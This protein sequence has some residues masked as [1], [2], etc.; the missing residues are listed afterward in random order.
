[1]SFIFHDA[2][3]GKIGLTTDNIQQIVDIAAGVEWHIENNFTLVFTTPKYIGYHLAQLT[4]AD[5]GL[6]RMVSHSTKDNA[7]VWVD[8]NAPAGLDDYELVLSRSLSMP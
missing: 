4:E 7:F 1:M 3:G 5:N 2:F 6:I 8:L